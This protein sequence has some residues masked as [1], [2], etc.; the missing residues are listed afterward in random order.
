MRLISEAVRAAGNVL[1]TPVKLGNLASAGGWKRARMVGSRDPVVISQASRELQSAAPGIAVDEPGTRRSGRYDVVCALLTGEGLRWEKARALL[2]GA[3]VPLAY[4]AGGRWYRINL[5][6]VSLL[7]ARSLGRL[8]LA[9]S[10]CGLYKMVM[11]TIALFDAARRLVPTGGRPTNPG[12]PDGRSVTFI[13]PNYNQRHLMDFC[14]PPLLAEA[15]LRSEPHPPSPLPANRE[16]GSMQAEACGTHAAGHRIIVVDD[17]STDDTAS[18]LREHYPQVRVVAL[19]RNR[20]FAGAVRAGIE[21]SDTPLFALINTDVQ[22]RPG[23][24]AAILPHFDRPDTFAVCSRIELPDASQMETGNVAPAWSG[25]LEPYHVPP[26]RP[27]PI[28]YAG[29]ASSVYDRAKYE[30]LGGFEP[31]YRPLYFEDIDLG[32]RAWRRGWCSLFEPK[33]SVFHQRRAWIGARFGDAYA[34]E[35]FLR[36]NLLFVWGNVR[37]PVMLVQNLAYVC[38]RMLTELLRGEGTTAR[39]FLRALPYLGR[40]IGKRWTGHRS[41]DLTDR[42]IMEAA[43]PPSAEE[44]VERE[45]SLP[46]HAKGKEERPSPLTPLPEGEEREAGQ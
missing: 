9:L 20:G 13:V 38:A 22:V 36:N 21:A 34:N 7:S 11:F 23:F 2:S 27:G 37:D 17:A 12:S 24:L 46:L 45:S 40:M 39:A 26:T 5:P 35:T 30:A 8:W 4:G 25:V 3:P 41:G 15:T 10:M 29:G 16:G 44:F 6:H 14:L 19:G 42:D 1:L 18:Y 28:L 32:Y 33:A 31:V 43:R